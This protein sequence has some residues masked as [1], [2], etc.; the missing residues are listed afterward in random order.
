MWRSSDEELEIEITAIDHR[1]LPT[2]KAF[3]LS[4]ISVNL[5]VIKIFN[6]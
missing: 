5:M 6:I 2:L 3:D 4:N 1:L